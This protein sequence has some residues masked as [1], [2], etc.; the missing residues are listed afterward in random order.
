MFVVF[1]P[2]VG[3]LEACWCLRRKQWKRVFPPEWRTNLNETN[4][5]SRSILPTYWT[6]AV[7]NVQ[8]MSFWHPEFIEA[9]RL[10]TFI[11]TG[12]QFDNARREKPC[13]LCNRMSCGVSLDWQFSVRMRVCGPSNCRRHRHAIQI[14]LWHQPT[15]LFASACWLH[16]TLDFLIKKLGGDKITKKFARILKRFPRNPSAH[17]ICSSSY[18]SSWV[19]RWVKPCKVVKDKTSWLIRKLR[20]KMQ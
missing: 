10:Q 14:P 7:L 3:T 15:R 2:P 6:I 1:S 19:K 20:F 16:V 4:R 11:H 12:F 5:Q 9:S 17:S 13:A 8:L 18:C